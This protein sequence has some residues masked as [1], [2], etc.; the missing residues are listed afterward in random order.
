MTGRILT[1]AESDSSGNSG[2]QADVKTILA[3]GGYATTALT[4]I[5][6]Q[7]GDGTC[8]FQVVDPLLVADQMR[9]VLGGIGADAI[10]VGV[11][12]NGIT[13]DMVADVIDEMVARDLPVVVDPSLV[14]RDGRLLVDEDTLATVKRRLLLR[15]TVLTA[16]LREAE[17]LT[18]MTLRD[19]DQMQ[20][21]A[22]ML[23]TLGAENVV[24]RCSQA[25]SAHELYF[26]ACEDEEVIFECPQ[27]PAG[28][29][30]AACATLASA[31]AVGM[32]QGMSAL[33]A[34]ARGLD[35]MYQALL[36]APPFA[37]GCGMLNHAFA[38]SLRHDLPAT[39]AVTR[40]S[41]HDFQG[42]MRA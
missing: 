36:Q 15:A 5:T 31:I 16:S 17:Y 7:G 34:I 20:H 18:G 3:L 32:G 33:D 39:G 6:A 25:V 24:L 8:E 30:P 4:A 14:G 41:L 27:V 38:I 21:A 26:V 35:F 23:R 13:V 9:T 10:K 42:G 28:H 37:K 22:T 40:R 12:N 19:I 1:I 11:L 2:I 29:V